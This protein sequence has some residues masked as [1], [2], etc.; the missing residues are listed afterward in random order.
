MQVCTSSSSCQLAP[1]CV[2]LMDAQ[3]KHV[4]SLL[5]PAFSSH[6]HPESKPTGEWTA[7]RAQTVPKSSSQV[8]SRPNEECIRPP[9]HSCKARGGTLIPAPK[10]HADVRRP[11][12]QPRT[13]FG[14]P[15]TPIKSQGTFWS[16]G[17]AQPIHCATNITAG[18]V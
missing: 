15:R 11:C 7:S 17:Q 8:E 6:M 3:N 2:K 13:Q 9:A 12:A 10:A 16:G 4:G 14:N 18:R 5:L 1:L